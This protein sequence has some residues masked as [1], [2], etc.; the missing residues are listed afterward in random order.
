[1][2]WNFLNNLNI[3]SLIAYIVIP[4]GGAILAIIGLITII[5]WIF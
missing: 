5:R 2:W 4:V 3:W 1:M